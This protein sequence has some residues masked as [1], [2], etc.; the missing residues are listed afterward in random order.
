MSSRRM[1]GLIFWRE[2]VEVRST[3][4]AGLHSDP[5]LLGLP[6]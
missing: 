6:D 3:H 4:A 5:S 2:G 1:V